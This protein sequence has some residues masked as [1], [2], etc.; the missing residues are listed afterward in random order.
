MTPPSSN[1]DCAWLLA[2]PGTQAAQANRRMAIGGDGRIESI[3]PAVGAVAGL[4]RNT[5]HHLRSAKRT[6]LSSPA[7]APPKARAAPMQN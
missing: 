4:W 7:A 6:A 5:Y 2:E 1:I 3:A